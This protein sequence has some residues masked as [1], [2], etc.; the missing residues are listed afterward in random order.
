MTTKI[1][2]EYAQHLSYEGLPAPVAGKAKGIIL[3]TLGCSLGGSR[4]ELVGMIDGMINEEG[5]R[6]ICTLIGRREKSGA[7]WCAFRNAA[8]ADALDFEDDNVYGHPA[9]TIVSAALAVAEETGAGGREMIAAIVAGYDVMARVGEA[10]NPSPERFAQVWGVGPHQVFGAAVAAA[11]LMQLHGDAFLYAMGLAGVGAPLPS[12]LSWNYR[13]RPLSWHKDSVHW[14]AW[15]GVSAARLARQGF[16]GPRSV[17]DGPHGFWI[18]SGS[19]RFDPQALL[20]G[21]G[22]D[23]RIMASSFKPYPACRWVHSALD[24][25]GNLV[26]E[27]KLLPSDIA[28][29]QIESFHL[30]QDYL[31]MDYAPA[32]MVDAEFSLPYSVAM[33]L[34]GVPPGPEWYTADRM[35]DPQVKQMASKVTLRITQEMNALLDERG[36]EAARAIITTHEGISHASMVPVAGGSPGNPLPQGEL[37][38]KFLRNSNSVLSGDQ[39]RQVMATVDSLDD[40]ERLSGLCELLRGESPG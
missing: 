35:T 25:V 26:R 24:A 36:M 40:H 14:P 11:K 13:E 4:T 29:V 22:T 3:D 28:G 37:E 20:R 9:S 12:G 33:I 34:L 21:L 27:H 19:D 31:F 23:F 5:G 1:L 8:A 7:S 18:M 32:N 10:I 16:I 30:V 6:P 15:L 39:A 38:A 17:L 2:A